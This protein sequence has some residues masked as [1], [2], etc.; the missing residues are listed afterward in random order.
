[1]ARALWVNKV[2]NQTQ[3]EK[4]AQ[5][6]LKFPWMSQ[7]LAE[8]DENYATE[9]FFKSLKGAWKAMCNYTHS[10]ALQM[11]R[12]F[13]NGEVKPSYSD[14]EIV[15]ALNA[16]NTMLMLLMRMFFVSMGCQREAD[17]T[18]KMILEYGDRI[19]AMP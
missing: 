10:G 18:K 17:E 15:E 13:T 11:A 2:A 6:E 3:I 7:M 12:R 9:N 5:D 8:I 1:M 16:T 14:A 4:A 19:V